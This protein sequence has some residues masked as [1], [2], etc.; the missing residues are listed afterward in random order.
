MILHP[1]QS[2]IAKDTHRFRV[3]CSGRRFGKTVLAVWEM[4]AMAA[5]KEDGRVAYAAPTIQ[6]ARDIAWNELKRV[7]AP[8][9]KNINETRLEITIANKHG[10]T[11]QI[12]LRG[13]ENI[14]TL[15]GQK[16]HMIVLDEVAMMRH[17]WEMWQEV[18]RPTLTDFRGEGMFISTPKGFNHFYDLYNFEA[19]DKDYKSFHFTSYDNPN[20]PRDEIEKAKMELP[21]DRFA[22]EYMADFRKSEGLVYKEFSRDVH[23]VDDIP[24]SIVETFGGVDFG[25]TN[26]TAVLTI[27]KDYEGRYFVADEWYKR[28]KTEDEVVEVVKNRAFSRVYPDPE[29]A[30]AIE[31]MRR[32]GINIR[33]VNKG[34]DS[35][36]S[37]I[38]KVREMFKANRLF[39][40]RSCVNTLMELE[41]Y[42][43]P[44]KQPDKNF[45]ELP[46]PEHNHGLDVLR[47]CIMS[48]ATGDGVERATTYLPDIY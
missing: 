3:I 41:Q 38:Q 2:E 29:N 32:A 36:V 26:P 24:I 47:Y 39:I 6:Q 27:K 8:I 33:E 12:I 25:F 31:A 7:C 1:A 4:F 18:L 48:D 22:Q 9:A 20:I 42:C 28:G 17:F 19:R 43:Y 5:S 23:V 40:H 11:S 16:Y 45:Q 30:S 35:I 44:D 15:R 21:D 37:G 34:K 13:W 46:I 14:E 10:G